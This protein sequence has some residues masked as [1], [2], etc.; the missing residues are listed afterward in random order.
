MTLTKVQVQQISKL[1][2]GELV[3]DGKDL[4]DKLTRSQTVR[5]NSEVEIELPKDML[6]QL[7]Q[8]SIGMSR[9][10]DE[11]TKEFVMEAIT[12]HLGGQFV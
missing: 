3:K 11:Y 9:P 8:Q 5:F 2:G 6:W 10:Y 7:K 12:Y 4:V 1:L